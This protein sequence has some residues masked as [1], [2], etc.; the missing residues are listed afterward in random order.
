MLS[1]DA[2]EY[3]LDRRRAS[4]V[5]SVSD[6]EPAVR[7]S[8]RPTRAC[9]VRRPSVRIAAHTRQAGPTIKNTLKRIFDVEQVT[10]SRRFFP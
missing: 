3:F 10:R 4:T 1:N 7:K 8:D 5:M 9:L 6:T 2:S